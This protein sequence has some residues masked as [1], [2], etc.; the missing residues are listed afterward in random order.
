MQVTYLRIGFSTWS[1][2]HN[3]VEGWEMG[4][5]NIVTISTHYQIHKKAMHHTYKLDSHKQM[6]YKLVKI[7]G[8]H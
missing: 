6:I 3:M 8:L 1:F 5:F 4:A 7:K 2:K